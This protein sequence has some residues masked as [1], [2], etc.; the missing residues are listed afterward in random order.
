LEFGS[1]SI[2]NPGVIRAVFLDRTLYVHRQS[3][4]MESQQSWSQRR[5]TYNGVVPT[6][7]PSFSGTLPAVYPLIMRTAQSLLAII[8]W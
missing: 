1:T 4:R 7:I 3:S 6:G 8:E 5:T 2:S